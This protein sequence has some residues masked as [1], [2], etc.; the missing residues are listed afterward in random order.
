MNNILEKFVEKIK[1]TFGENL[2]SIIL[3]G[4]KASGEDT[5]KYS[6]YNLLLILKE[7]KFSNLTLF[8]RRVKGWL[9]AG[10]PPPLLFTMARLEKSADVFPIE[11]LD[12]KDNH[13]LLY[14]EDPFLSLEIKNTY[15]RH[16][17]ESE[18]KGKLLKL[19][20]GYMISG[21]KG[22]LVRELL[23]NSLSSFLV[24]FRH[25]LRLFG[26]TPPLKKLESLE[27]LAQG[28]GLD[29]SVFLTISKLK[30]GDK[31][32]KKTDPN[33]LM[34]KYFQEIEKVVAVVDNL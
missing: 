27:L 14:G 28:I 6:D 34:E 23:V 30:H 15:L 33:L 32:A 5:R 25:L 20:Q 11:F 3:Y 10:N 29:T 8:N 2:K 31:E 4:S 16:Q 9:K 22:R 24:I 18:L 1:S 12:I 21:G 17:C 13:K 7:I 19:E 26:K